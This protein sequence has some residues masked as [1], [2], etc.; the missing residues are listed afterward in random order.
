MPL[1][2]DSARAA[3]LNAGLVPV[4]LYAP[5]MSTPAGQVIP[6][7]QSPAAGTQVLPGSQQALV[8]FTVSQGAP[9]PLGNVTAPN[10]MGMPSQVA[11]Q[12]LAAVGLSVDRPQWAVNVAQEGTVIAQSVTAGASVPAGTIVVLT[13]SMGPNRASRVVSVPSVS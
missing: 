11:Y 3:I 2:P 4:V 7:S 5:S 8:S 10:C 1:D 12:A 6:G 9:T 13:F